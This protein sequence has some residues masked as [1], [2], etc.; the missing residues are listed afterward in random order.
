MATM[1]SNTSALIR[2]PGQS[3]MSASGHV[4]IVWVSASFL[5]QLFYS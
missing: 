3:F 4:V 2:V 5:S 1:L